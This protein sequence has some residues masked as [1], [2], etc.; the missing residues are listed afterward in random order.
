M[1]KLIHSSLAAKSTGWIGIPVHPRVVSGTLTFCIVAAV[2]TGDSAVAQSAANFNTKQVAPAAPVPAAPAKAAAVK[3][4][5]PSPSPSA[6]PS[7]Y[8]Q[9]EEVEAYVNTLSSIFSI[10]N[11][12]T[13]PFGQ[14]QDP[15]AKPIVKA[16]TN[17]P[18]TR[19]TQVQAFP[20]ADIVRLIKVTTIMP[21]E[22]RFLVGTRSIKEGDSI[23]LSFRGRNYKVV[24]AGV[25]S[26]SIVFR[27]SESGE[28]ASLTLNLLPVGMT[29]GN[30][31]IT[32][33]GM[34]PENAGAPL[35]LDSHDISS[36][37]TPLN[38]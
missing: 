11:R 34:V 26:R 27:N 12:T 24:V 22:K 16:T 20:F 37:E 15:D 17:K 7:R 23:P 30:G 4:D 33:P 8:V 1:G 32:A 6:T 38:P 28:V 2:F 31:K 36:P 14:Y 18:K 25:T 10:R 3:P 35:E 29:P 13:D 21:G 19:A 5:K 9:E